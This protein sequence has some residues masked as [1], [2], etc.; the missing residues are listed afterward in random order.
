MIFENRFIVKDAVGNDVLFNSNQ[1]LEL[2]RRYGEH[3]NG[4]EK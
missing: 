1:M 2:I 4:K 3:E